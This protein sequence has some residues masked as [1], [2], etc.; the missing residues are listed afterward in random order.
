MIDLVLSLSTCLQ[1]PYLDTN[2]QDHM[3]PWNPYTSMF[4]NLSHGY[5]FNLEYLAFP[6]KSIPLF[7]DKSL[8]FQSYGY[9][10]G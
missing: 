7:K 9:C 8:R 6:N 4:V 1:L 5:L 2:N 3:H 10:I